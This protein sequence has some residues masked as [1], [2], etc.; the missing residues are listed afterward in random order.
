VKQAEW[1]R[2]SNGRR[3]VGSPDLDSEMFHPAIVGA[4]DVEPPGLCGLHR[5]AGGGDGHQVVMHHEVFGGGLG[6]KAGE[7]VGFR[8]TGGVPDPDSQNARQEL[9]RFRQQDREAV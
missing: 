8:E 2:A 6:G 9:R 4:V 3:A 7:P 1:S 5:Q